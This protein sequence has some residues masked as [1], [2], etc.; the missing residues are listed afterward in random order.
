MN[1]NTKLKL[2]ETILQQTIL[3]LLLIICWIVRFSACSQLKYM[4]DFDLYVAIAALLNSLCA[5]IICQKVELKWNWKFGKC[6]TT[7]NTMFSCTVFAIT[8]ICLCK[9]FSMI[10]EMFTCERMIF[11]NM[12]LTPNGIVGNELQCPHAEDFDRSKS[13]NHFCPF[14][15]RSSLEM[16]LENQRNRQLGLFAVIVSAA[17]IPSLMVAQCKICVLVIATIYPYLS[18][19][20]EKPTKLDD[21]SLN[22]DLPPPYQKHEMP[23]SSL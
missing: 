8:A 13:F 6:V 15:N 10:V 22:Y 20:I 1:N 19:L 11:A 4:V 12:T 23:G 21:A 9:A 18:K 17:V 14:N 3:A 5:M 16:I 7:F 2:K